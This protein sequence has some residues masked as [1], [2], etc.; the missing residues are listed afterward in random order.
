MSDN[1]VVICMG[2]PGS[3]RDEYLQE[4]K[5]EK[6]FFYYHLFDYIVKEAEKE[7]Y[8]L[9][10]FNVLDFYESK[11]KK[12]ETFR[13]NA[14]KRITEEIQKKKGIHVISTPYHFEWKGKAYKGLRIE[15]VKVLNPELFLVI[16]DD[17]IRVK[18]RLSEDPQWKEHNFT[19]VEIAQWRR[20][21]VIGVYNL[22]R[23][24]IPYKNF[25]LVAKDHGIE[26]LKDLIFNRQKKTIYLS[27]PITGEGEDFF[28]GVR[29]FA[30]SL[31]QYYT[32]FDPYM[33]KDWDIVEAWRRVQNKA[34]KEKSQV[35]KKINISIEY[36]DGLKKYEIETW[37]IEAAINTIRAQVIDLDYKTLASCYC[38][39]AYHPREQISAG[40]MCEMVEAKSLAKFVYVYYP[41]EPSPFFE[42]Y[43]TKIFLDEKKMI[44]YMK[45]YCGQK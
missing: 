39:I 38:T 41:F 32:I 4:L 17:L 21:E 34:R 24:F 37:D 29:N 42:W 5:K 33:I 1:V 18:A 28:K 16:I 30:T 45:A 23:I 2:Q 25:Y 11:P 44:D 14:L 12:L 6:D 27:H 26:L 13:A 43:S 36:S 9:N 31:Q 15:E 22:A 7:G 8:V 10:K 19:L 20:E 3:G 35:P 40:V